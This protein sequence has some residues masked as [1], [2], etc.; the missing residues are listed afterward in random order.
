MNASTPKP[1]NYAVIFTSLR[2]NVYEDYNDMA[3][4]MVQLEEQ[5]F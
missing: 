4:C 5:R 2:T 1:P 3:L